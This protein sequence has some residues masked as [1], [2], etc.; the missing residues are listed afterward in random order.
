MNKP[1]VAPAVFV[2]AVLVLSGWL[3]IARADKPPAPRHQPA[4]CA[5]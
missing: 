3:L 2:L 4:D 1:N 5:H